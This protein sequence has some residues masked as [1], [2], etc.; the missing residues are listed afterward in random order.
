LKVEFKIEKRT[1]NKKMKMEKNKGKPRLGHFSLAGLFPP[2][3]QPTFS[4]RM[5]WVRLTC[6]LFA[7]AVRMWGRFASHVLAVMWATTPSD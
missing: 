7:R 3:R 6:G 5:A 4:L 2:R 1:E